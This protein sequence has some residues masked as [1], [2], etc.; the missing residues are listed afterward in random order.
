MAAKAS[1]RSYT[2]VIGEIVN[3]AMSRYSRRAKAQAQS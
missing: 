3:L 2:Q 1:G